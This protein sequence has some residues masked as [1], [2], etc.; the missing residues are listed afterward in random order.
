MADVVR[1]RSGSNRDSRAS[2]IT[3]QQLQ[4]L[5]SPPDASTSERHAQQTIVNALAGPLS[6]A[7]IANVL[8]PLLAAEQARATQLQAQLALS[9]QQTTALLQ[10]TRGHFQALLQ[11]TS[12]LK[13]SHESL[14]DALIDHT[15]VLVSSASQRDQALDPSP[16]TPNGTTTDGTT[17]REK[18]EAFNQRRKELEVTKQWFAVLVKAEDLGLRAL[19]ALEQGSLPHAQ[20]L[21]I[22]LV[23]YVKER[24]AAAPQLT[25]T[26][27]LATMA[28]SVWNGMI[29]I[30]SS[31]VLAALEGIGWP[32]P[33][34]DRAT[35]DAKFQTFQTAFSD[36]L[37]LQKI[38]MS[39]PLPAASLLAAR[40]RDSPTP[41]KP[42]IAFQP[43]V[44]PL[45]L[46]FK[47]HFEGDKNTNRID[48]PEYP[49]SHVLNLLTA[50]ERFLND[51]VQE[52]LAENG[53]SE[54]NAVNEFTTL[55]LPPL[56]TRVKHH[57]P[58][59]LDM[60][61]ILAHTIFQLLEFDEVLRR[62]GYRPRGLKG[63]WKGLSDIIL[64]RKDW[65]S[66]WL[67]GER[68]FFDKRY[69]SAIS[70]QDAWQ[71]VSEEDYDADD[72]RSGTRPTNSAL[73]V[74]E[75]AQSLA[76]RYR[77]L[78][79][80]HG[81]PFLFKL[82]LPLL[83]S[84][85]ERVTSSLDA[86]ESLAFGMLPGA[87]ATQTAA[88]A[89]VGG[90]LR[91]VRAG[92][93]ARWM[94]EKCSEW[95]EDAFFLGLYDYLSSIGAPDDLRNQAKE[96]LSV[97][98][99]TLFDRERLAFE[100]LADRSEDLIVRHCV[101]EVLSDLKPYLGRRWDYSK[102]E[103]EDVEVDSLTS[104]LNAPLALFTTLLKTL[105]E[106]YP[107]AVATTLYRRIAV[108][109]STSLYDRLLVNRTW[110]EAGAHQLNY[111]IDHGFLQAGREAGIRR[112]VSRG[113]DKLVGGA[114][115]MALPATSFSDDE[116]HEGDDQA[117]NGSRKTRVAPHDL[118]FSKVMQLAFDDS[119]PEGEGTQFNVAMEQ[120]GVGEVLG[121]VEVQQVMRRRPECWR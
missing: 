55:L 28:T 16:D 25:L 2:T 49:L 20:E 51:E 31:R 63:D 79:T 108:N 118:T 70:A 18:L 39:H 5:L 4:R 67:E 94:S 86:F 71:I 73:K 81:L 30:L 98:E 15:E 21:Y 103:G 1:A 68:E 47:W 45:L 96:L 91:V 111:D 95:G 107:H 87:L 82:H 75:L 80:V 38:Q 14:E 83:A 40:D 36:M 44:H 100:R 102:Q 11:R 23:N 117:E 60:P 115:I 106:S 109:L 27:H 113:W 93:S 48:K 6:P 78:P 85:A 99:G 65:Y 64:G 26:S 13:S 84:Y 59:L 89:G 35:L 37:V 50:H 114:K 69:F 101:R 17:L 53:F 24:H 90:L 66:R 10:E 120:L 112:G 54:V 104:E 58:Q 57:I 72:G 29:K 116:E 12:E 41:A 110:S 9:T 76:D 88:T 19:R 119:V 61:P 46:R 92:V 34:K 42:L 32:K 43:L 105:V 97:S 62:R 7:R 3:S 77:P 22:E 56:M 121:K 52:L 74:A 8:E 33:L